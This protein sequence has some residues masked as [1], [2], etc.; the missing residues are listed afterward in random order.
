M[1]EKPDEVVVVCARLTTP[2]YM[3]DNKVGKCSECKLARPWPSGSQENQ[4]WR[5]WMSL[6]ARNRYQP[7]AK[8]LP[9]ITQVKVLKLGAIVRGN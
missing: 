8:K 4:A 7:S 9:M 6:V 2:L 3:P 5:K 1:S